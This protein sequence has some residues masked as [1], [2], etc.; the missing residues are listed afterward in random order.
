MNEQQAFHDAMARDPN[1]A[2]VRGAYADWLDE[3]GQEEAAGKLRT[4]AGVLTRLPG[5]DSVKD[6]M[7][8]VTDYRTPLPLWMQRLV[9]TRYFR[10][11]HASA[12]H[13]DAAH[14]H[15]H[16][17]LPADELNALGL[18]V[19]V[20]RN[21][22]Y[23]SSQEYLDRDGAYLPN[24]MIAHMKAAEAAVKEKVKLARMKVPAGGQISGGGLETGGVFQ[25][26]GQFAARARKR[27]RNVV[28][29]WL[30]NRVKLARKKPKA[31]LSIDDLRYDN[32]PGAPRKPLPDVPA[33]DEEVHKAK[34]KTAGGK[35]EP[36]KLRSKLT[37]R[38]LKDVEEG[39]ELPTRLHLSKKF[40]NEQRA[41]HEE[42]ANLDHDLYYHWANE[43]ARHVQRKHLPGA[44]IARLRNPKH[45]SRAKLAFLT[46][47]L[48]REVDG[49]KAAFADTGGAAKWYG[50]HVGA[51][52]RHLR[53]SFHSGKPED[54]ELWGKLDKKTGRVVGGAATTIAKLLVAATSGGMKP[55]ENY[56]T[57]H[58]M[59]AAGK[60]HAAGS[61][62]PF[63]TIP[64]NQGE[65]FAAWVEAAAKWHERANSGVTR[66]DILKP[67]R[68]LK[69]RALW[70]ERVMRPMALDKKNGGRKLSNGGTNSVARY[71]GMITQYV[72]DRTSAHYGAPIA[73]NKGKG[74]WKSP[75]PTSHPRPMF[76]TLQPDD[77]AR[78]PA[79]PGED[80]YS[81][82]LV[83]LHGMKGQ[84]RSEKLPAVDAHGKLQAPGW[85]SR[86]EQ[87]MD[88]VNKINAVV[89]FFSAKLGSEREG[90]KAAANFFTTPHD[91][92]AFTEIVK[93]VY[94]NHD[95]HVAKR[96][97]VA[98]DENRGFYYEGEHL[99]GAFL[100]GP[101]FGAF[102]MNLHL[103]QP[104]GA[105]GMT[106][107]EHSR[108]FG[109]HL[110]ADLWWSRDWN[111]MLG[112]L[113]GPDNERN[114]RQETPR[115]KGEKHPERKLM[116]K[117]AQQA[118]EAAGLT[119]VA[120]LQAVLWYYEQQKPRWFGVDTSST[121]YLDGVNLV[122]G[123]EGK[124][125]DIHPTG[126]INVGKVKDAK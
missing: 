72:A 95:R 115:G 24:Q 40:G 37:I 42:V 63:K 5:Y 49:A 69:D 48:V 110:T 21:D 6:R 13:G 78:L 90:M 76:K 43:V 35:A 113:F 67:G 57:A 91:K 88:G 83:A 39:L 122:A 125:Y 106:T 116:R 89:A 73:V 66:A 11:L 17:G 36:D 112:S 58:A 107:G 61:E 126:A 32:K 46:R 121:S 75:Y 108:H 104:P 7:G 53:D 28:L 64:E 50:D 119:N 92:K 82:K 59:I 30:K 47:R 29:A 1:D 34:D 16:V 8:S 94:K 68:S 65:E 81:G 96:L 31:D 26:G 102:S 105:S 41:D 80:D 56:D 101:K 15:V 44:T 23:M 71:S 85:T 60:R 97:K 10:L 62:N 9:H 123:R 14:H 54:D 18:P 100:L 109:G 70:Y 124:K 86:N 74:G 12:K 111:V 52:S 99:P 55:H 84:T 25:Q 45:L 93:W 27:I 98:A 19:E 22:V 51:M 2:H 3:N 77:K 87:V 38:E 4:W 20:P 118:A 33:F 114:A 120:E 79:P 103:D 117:A